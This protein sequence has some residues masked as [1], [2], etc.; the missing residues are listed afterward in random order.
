MMTTKT[1]NYTA[2]MTAELIEA[3]KKADTSEARLAV[4]AFYAEKLGKTVNS[5]RAKLTREKVYIAKV[6]TNK[7]GAKPVKKDAM[8]TVIADKIGMTVEA[9]DSLEK[10]NKN[11]LEAII[12][13]LL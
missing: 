8:V 3:Y 13:A 5:V 9:C 7:N 4:V 1:E 10:V 11:V 2:E 6:Y 12:K